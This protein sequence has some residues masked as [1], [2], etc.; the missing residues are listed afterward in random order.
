LPFLEELPWFTIPLIAGLMAALLVSL[1][2]RFFLSKALIHRWEK[3]LFPGDPAL[4]ESD[5]RR[6]VSM[7]RAIASTR[8]KTWSTLRWDIL[9]DL[10]SLLTGYHIIFLEKGGAGDY[11]EEGELKFRFSL[12]RATALGLVLIRTI[13]Q[14]IVRWPFRWI[15]NRR[16]KL[17][18]SSYNFGRGLR[19]WFKRHPWAEAILKGF[20]KL[21]RIRILGPILSTLTA[22]ILFPFIGVPALLWLFLRTLG[23]GLIS[24]SLYRS[25]YTFLLYQSAYHGLFL[26]K[27]GHWKAWKAPTIPTK[28]SLKKEKEQW[29]RYWKKAIPKAKNRHPEVFQRIA[30]TAQRFGIAPEKDLHPQGKERHLFHK[31]GLS[32]LEGV[33]NLNPWRKPKGFTLPMKYAYALVPRGFQDENVSLSLRKLRLREIYW[34]LDYSLSRL[35]ELLMSLPGIGGDRGLLD[36][37]EVDLALKAGQLWQVWK[38]WFQEH[39]D[40]LSPLLA[41]SGDALRLYRAQKVVRHGGQILGFLGTKIPGIRAFFAKLMGRATPWG[42]VISLGG[43]WLWHSIK[44]YLTEE[45][46]GQA[47]SVLCRGILLSWGGQGNQNDWSPLPPQEEASR[48][49]VE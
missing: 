48:T 31:I 43:E 17:L 40:T 23:F 19:G 49:L 20:Q 12:F 26:F 4:W 2:T 25:F 21:S 28:T 33:K 1:T 14:K 15:G 7:V 37:I 27:K 10:Q 47:F 13:R 45:F 36:R 22:L 24:E 42:A 18:L 16:L 8:L 3:K 29:E 6:V 46:R 38:D 9:E 11:R 39:N 5:Q 34:G 32:T 44:H 35:V 30:W 41:H